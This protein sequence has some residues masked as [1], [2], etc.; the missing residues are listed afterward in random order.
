MP[1]SK[2]G[3]YITEAQAEDEADFDQSPP[4]LWDEADPLVEQ[5]IGGYLHV[6]KT[7]NDQNAFDRCVDEFGFEESVKALRGVSAIA[8][9][10]H[11][12]HK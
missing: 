2:S 5:I 3:G 11:L 12:G 9:R 7:M 4:P 8:L 6:R 10:I 1:F